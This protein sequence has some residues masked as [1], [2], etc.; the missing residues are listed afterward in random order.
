MTRVRVSVDACAV[1]SV[2]V[3]LK[4]KMERSKKQQ[5]KSH[6]EKEIGGLK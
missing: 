6:V 2:L 4:R 3:A 5:T 1:A